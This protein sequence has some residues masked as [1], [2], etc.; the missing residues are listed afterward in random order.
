MT[1]FEQISFQVYNL[2]LKT[3]EMSKSQYI[4]KIIKKNWNARL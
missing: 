2:H 1:D 3:I 4:E